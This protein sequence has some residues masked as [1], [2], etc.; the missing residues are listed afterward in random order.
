VTQEWILR[1]F[2]TAAGAIWGDAPEKVMAP[3][4][5]DQSGS[6]S[7]AKSTAPTGAP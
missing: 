2:G 3:A 7:P 5:D 6:R 1:G 4:G